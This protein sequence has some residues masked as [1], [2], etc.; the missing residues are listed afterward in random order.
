[1]RSLLCLTIVKKTHLSKKKELDVMSWI[2]KFGTLQLSS[3]VE[4]NDLHEISVDL[5]SSASFREVTLVQTYQHVVA[6]DDMHSRSLA[7]PLIVRSIS[8][9]SVTVTDVEGGL[10]RWLRLL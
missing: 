8:V 4:H 2:K 5:V 9:E 7:G 3:P 10:R 1:V 6:H